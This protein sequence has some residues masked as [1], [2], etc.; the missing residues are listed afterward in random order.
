VTEQIP[1]LYLHAPQ[2]LYFIIPRLG[3]DFATIEGLERMKVSRILGVLC[4]L[5]TS[6]S[7]YAA[8]TPNVTISVDATARSPQ[9]LPRHP[10]YSRHPR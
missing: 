3:N 4:L 9:D 5:V 6:V 7:S 2:L 1:F 10:A 8:N